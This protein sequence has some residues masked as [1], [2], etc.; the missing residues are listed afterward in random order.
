LAEFDVGKIIEG[1]APYR[2]DDDMRVRWAT[3]YTLARLNTA[4]SS[5]QETVV[6]C[7]TE[8]LSDSWDRVRADVAA[9]LGRL[10]A[11]EALPALRKTRD[12]PSAKV[13]VWG[14]WAMWKITGDQDPAVRLM[15]AC[16]FNESLGG[17]WESAY[18]LA[19]F[20]ELPPLT[21]KALLH[22]TRLD[23]DPPQDKADEFEQ[24]RI[25]R[26]AISTLKKQAPESLE[27]SGDQG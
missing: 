10:Q 24:N 2:N 21:V 18:L 22:V 17:K 5:H 1:V 15:T 9:M 19:D 6:Q 4:D 16:L 26:T 11:N 23:E 27:K 3:Y 13:R 14:A 25:K 12:D 7:F 20:E 8:M